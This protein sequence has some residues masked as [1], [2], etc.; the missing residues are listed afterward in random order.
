MAAT[1]PSRVERA[2]PYLTRVSLSTRKG[3]HNFRTLRVCLQWEKRKPI[4][5]PTRQRNYRQADNVV[6]AQ[7]TTR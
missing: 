4:S 7:S 3:V 2:A 5:R 1:S 6:G